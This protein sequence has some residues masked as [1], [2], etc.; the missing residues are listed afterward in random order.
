MTS[1]PSAGRD[2]PVA[3]NLPAPL[4]VDQTERERRESLRSTL[5]AQFSEARMEQLRKDAAST[6]VVK[7]NSV[8]GT[9]RT[10]GYCNRGD[11]CRW[12]HPREARLSGKPP[13]KG[14]PGKGR[15]GC[16]KPDSKSGDAEI[17]RGGSRSE[18]DDSRGSV[19]RSGSANGRLRSDDPE[20]VC[21]AHLE[22][23][24]RSECRSVSSPPCCTS[25]RGECG[26]RS[27]CLYPESAGG[28]A[29]AATEAAGQDA[30]QYGNGQNAPKEPMPPRP[31]AKAMT[32]NAKRRAARAAR[33]AADDGGEE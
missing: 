4:T 7:K 32:A 25:S 15:G 13:A 11:D 18:S 30:D 6:T 21:R 10:R 33:R 1:G 16:S 28:R 9:W 17:E 5:V 24:T 3:S 26:H 20:Q 23:K 31:T 27:E 8:C 22:P 29:H 19:P 14:K 12:L 2:A